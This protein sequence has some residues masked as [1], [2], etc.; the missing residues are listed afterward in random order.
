MFFNRWITL[1]KFK[2]YVYG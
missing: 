2:N 1:C